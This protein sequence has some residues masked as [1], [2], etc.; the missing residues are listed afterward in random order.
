MVMR[1]MVIMAIVIMASQVAFYKVVVE[2]MMMMMMMKLAVVSVMANFL[3]G[4]KRR[5][6]FP[7]LT[8]LGQVVDIQGGRQA[9]C[10][11]PGEL[12]QNSHY[13]H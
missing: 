12:V 4:A 5:N 13:H 2:I 8:F 11:R 1:R 9:E 3:D 7:K 10:A 6:Y